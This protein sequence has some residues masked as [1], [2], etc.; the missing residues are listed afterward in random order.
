ME[1]YK[2]YIDRDDINKY[3]PIS[4]NVKDTDLSVSIQESMIQELEY[5]L[6]S[7]L[8]D[9][10]MYLYSIEKNVI[11]ITTG[12]TTIIE[13]SNADDIDTLYKFKV[14]QLIGTI[15]EMNDKEFEVI[16]LSGT[17]IAVNFDSTGLVY[18]GGGVLSNWQRPELFDLRGFIIPFL[19]Y[20]SYYRYTPKS[21]QHSTPYGY[22]QK[23][24][25]Y[26]QYPT[27]AILGEDMKAV[28][29]SIEFWKQKLVKY[30]TDNEA[31]LK[32]FGYDNPEYVY[33]NDMSFSPIYSKNRRLLKNFR[34]KTRFGR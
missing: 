29:K 26:S 30:L 12:V 34:T 27:P 7:M 18:E 28:Q 3:T 8:Y 16:S 31:I 20:S 21:S 1:Q 10:L 19:V 33:K 5:I 2:D 13:V 23:N 4:I 17:Q 9:T 24:N 25:Q 32:A 22:V 6:T 14:S 11:S 15:S